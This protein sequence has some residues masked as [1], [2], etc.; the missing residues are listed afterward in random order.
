[1]KRFI[2]AIAC[3]CVL[4][5]ATPAWSACM[6]A[7]REEKADGWLKSETF[8]DAAG[9]RESAY[10]LQLNTAA[11]LEGSDASDKVEHTRTVHVFSAK[12]DVNKRIRRL[13]NK[14]VRVRG[15]PFG[16]HTAH[17]HARIVMD[18]SEISAR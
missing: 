18:V 15:T 5:A 7:G 11:C 8:K 3:A 14:A 16:A 1:M 2:A 12:D 6:K 4:A 17:H 10:I 9:H 13:V